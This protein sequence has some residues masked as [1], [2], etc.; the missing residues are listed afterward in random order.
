M[1]NT[2]DKLTRLG[3]PGSFSGLMN[4]YENNY[5]RLAQ[6]IPE[7]RVPVDQAVSRSTDDLD[8]HLRVIE[9]TA[10][11]TTLHLTYWFDD[12]DGRRADPSLTVRIYHDAHMAE[13][14]DSVRSRC[15]FLADIDPTVGGWLQRQYARNQLLNKWL[16][17]LLDHGHGFAM[18]HRPRA[19][20]PIG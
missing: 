10:Y 14:I 9:R 18:A 15:D 19:G 8:L 20:S 4:L 16:S 3:R 6:L 12:A 17:Y 1:L 7:I 2:R 13:S 11:T 5:L